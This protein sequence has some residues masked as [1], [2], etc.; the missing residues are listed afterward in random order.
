MK[1]RC[2]ENGMEHFSVTGE[3]GKDSLCFEKLLPFFSIKNEIVPFP[4]VFPETMHTVFEFVFIS[5][6]LGKLFIKKR[7]PI[8]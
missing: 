2:V 4:P 6:W 5:L 7:G 8:R 3:K 1:T